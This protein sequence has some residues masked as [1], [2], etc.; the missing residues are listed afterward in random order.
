MNPILTEI[1]STIIPSAPYLIA[2]YV[3]L[4]AALVVWLFVQ[5][6]AQKKLDQRL[7][8]LEEELAEKRDERA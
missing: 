4:L 1:Y 3:L 2:A 6:R 5:F 7:S 8:M